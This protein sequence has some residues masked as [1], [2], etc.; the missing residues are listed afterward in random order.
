MLMQRAAPWLAMLA[1]ACAVVAPPPGGPPDATPPTLVKALP[2]SGANLPDFR[3]SAVFQFSEVISEGTPNI[4]LGTGALERLFLLSPTEQVPSVRWQRRQVS[5]RPREGW[6]PNTVYRIE[7]L[8]GI[9]DLRN[10]RSDAKRVI[11]FTTGGDAP[12]VT[13]RG[14][15]YDWTTAQPLRGM[16]VEAFLVKDSL[17]YK[18]TTDSTGAFAIGPLR[19]DVYVVSAVNDANH[20]LKRDPREQFDSVRVGP[21]SLVTGELWT[22]PHD[23]AGPR[24]QTV[25]R[26]DSVSAMLTFSQPLDPKQ[27]LDTSM[28][29]VRKLPDSTAI[30]VAGL[31]LADVYDSLRQARQAVISDSLRKARPDTAAKPAGAPK[32]PVLPGVPQR[33]LN[34]IPGGQFSPPTGA[35][36]KVLSRKALPT[37]LVVTV[38]QPWDS[39]GRYVIEVTGVR[40]VNKVAATTKNVLAIDPP[41]GPP[42]TRPLRT[43][44]DSAQAR[45]AAAARDSLKAKPDSARRA[46]TPADSLKARM[47]SVRKTA[48]P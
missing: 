32:L 19:P 39:V 43:A 24:L 20:N 17:R 48:P 34:E 9:T 13:I 35:N 3:G 27:A 22:F 44:R 30:R 36:G 47:D 45:A 42:G 15:A 41:S 16:L 31:V 26:N 1:M 6:R 4:G 11:V 21:D 5:V 28:V 37:R 18:G 46:A 23:T 40:N 29:T 2:D 12:T 38:A 10:N 14:T 8:P 7:L 25:A 33:G